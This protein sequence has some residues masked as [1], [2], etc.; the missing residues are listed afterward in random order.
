MKNFLFV[1]FFLSS[2]SLANCPE[3]LFEKK[4][5]PYLKDMI[6]TISWLDINPMNFD[7]TICRFVIRY[8]PCSEQY[9]LT[10]LLPVAIEKTLLNW[11]LQ[12][13]G[14]N[15]K[16]EGYCTLENIVLVLRPGQKS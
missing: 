12:N 16:T 15:K 7:A 10:N 4:T 8:Y 1:L 14:R 5:Y 11:Q 6:P 9:K 2:V 3:D 13:K